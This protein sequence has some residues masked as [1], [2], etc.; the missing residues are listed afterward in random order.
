AYEDVLIEDSRKDQNNERIYYADSTFFEVFSYEVLEGN[1]S[2]CLKEPFTITMSETAA[3]KYFGQEPELGSVL[4]INFRGELNPLRLTAIFKDFPH[5]SHIQADIIVSFSSLNSLRHE[6]MMTNWL[7]SFHYSY[8]LVGDNTDLGELEESMQTM[9]EEYFGPDILT[10]LS[11]DNP[12]EFLTLKLVPITDIHLTANRTWEIEPP[13]SETSVFIFSLVSILLLVIAGINFMNLSTARASQRALEVGIRKVSG[14]SKKHLIRQFLGESLIFSFLAL[15]L[16]FLIIEL[17]L[18]TFSSFTGKDIS[19]K[20]IFMGWNALIILGVWIVTALLSG[21]Y[22]AF[23]LSSYKPVTVLKGNRAGN[24]ADWFRKVLVVGQFAISVGLIICALTVYRQLQYINEKDLG[25]NREGVLDIPIEDRTIYQSWDALQK[26]L[27]ELPEVKS[28]TR[29]MVIPTDHRYTDSPHLLRDNPKPFFPIVNRADEHFIP[30]MEISMLAGQ[31]FQANMM[32]DSLVYYIIND[33]ARKMFGFKSPLEAI[34]KEI[35]LLVGDGNETRGWGPIIGVCEDF[36]FQALTEE[37]K[38]MVISSSSEGHNHITLRIDESKESE[39]NYKIK[40]IWE[41]YFPGKIYRSTFIE[42]VFD[43]QHLTESRL[44][45]ILL[46]F[47]FLSVFVSCLGLLGLSIFS[48]EQRRKEIGIRKSLG[49]EVRQIVTLISAEFSKLIFISNLIAFPIAYFILR[50]WLRNFPYRRDMEIWVF[51]AAALVA[52][53]AAL[54]T[55]LVQ[56]YRA[57]RLNPADVLKYE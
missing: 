45:S 18:P 43:A 16:S 33:K 40:E 7:S 54:L 2:T 10:Y 22:P 56:T 44:Q 47:T 23:F 49:A 39:A 4:N 8:I 12:K 32:N 46:I 55:V 14:A 36:H 38:P 53:I 20:M 48:L 9:V 50:E 17:A 29:S 42:E 27:L 15:M 37:I 31:N 30:L 3:R 6:M 13:G 25:Y 24:G 28:I 26:D 41:K 34:G 51:L 11:I 52:W 35:G 21:I 1:P 5:N 19:L 57:G